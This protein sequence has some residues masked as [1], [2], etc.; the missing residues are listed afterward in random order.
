MCS[1]YSDAEQRA[2]VR[3]VLDYYLHTANLASGFLCRY[4]TELT[5]PQLLP[6]IVIEEIGEPGQ[7]AKWLERERHAMLAMIGRAAGEGHAPHAWELP[8]VAGW[9]LRGEV[10]Q[11]SLVAAQESA[12]VVA[13]RQG[14]LA[15]QAMAHQHLGWL[16]FLLGDIISVGHHMDEAAELARQLGDGRLRAL[17]GLSSAYVLHSQGRIPE[18]TAQ[19]GMRCSTIPPETGKEW[20]MLFMQSAGTLSSFETISI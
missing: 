3:R 12:L 5:R 16:R 6:G 7:A 2:A 8:W 17:V 15:G 11:Q 18:A 10:Y 13:V 9:Y 19:P 20:P 14:D 1:I 4:A